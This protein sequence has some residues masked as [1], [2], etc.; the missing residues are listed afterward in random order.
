MSH[1]YVCR[2]ILPE[3]RSQKSGYILITS[4]AAGLLTHIDSLTYSVTKHA[5]ISLAEWIAINN[6]EFG[7]NVSVLCPQAVKTNMILGRENDI[8]SV[9][10]ILFLLQLDCF[11]VL[12]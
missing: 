12:V 10:G 2:Y 11:L 6:N 9:D 4:S 5:A 3:F 7:V 1:V 8:A